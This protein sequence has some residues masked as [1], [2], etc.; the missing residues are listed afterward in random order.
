MFTTKIIKIDA[1]YVQV[2][3]THVIDVE[4]EVYRGEEKLENRRFAY[5]L[6]TTKDTILADL[7]KYCETL[8]S[9]EEVAARSAELDR[10]L[11]EVEK[12]KSDLLPK[13]EEAKPT[14]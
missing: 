14:E 12:L 10:Q 7:D 2:D 9:D 3:S 5:P 11:T 4:V 1:T 6:G 8:A 13:K